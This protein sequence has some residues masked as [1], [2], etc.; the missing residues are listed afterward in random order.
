MKI[1]FIPS[2]K[3]VEMYVDK[4]EPAIKSLP[5]WY[6]KIQPFDSKNPIFNDNG[7][8]VNRNIKMCMPLFDSFN[9]GYT[10]KTWCD[11]YIENKDGEL[12]YHYAYGPAPLE[13]RGE[14]QIPIEEDFYSVDFV[15]KEP[16]IP[17]TPKG[18]STLYLSPLNHFETTTFSVSAV[19]D[20]DRYYH[21]PFGNNPF[22]IKKG[23]YGVIPK[24]TPMYQMIPFKRDS[25]ESE[26]L[27]FDEN[28]TQKNFYKI[29]EKFWA[30]YKKNMWVK[31]DF[32]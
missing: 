14:S 29:M 6:K 20:T 4:P 30:V 19:I 10:Q 13:V 27:N 22:F 7:E 8:I 32:S 18:Y 15:W 1:S 17:K 16:W 5:E 3:E 11:I 23:F 25:W 9:M 2:S 31:K 21:T 12:Y 28:K 26:F 24:G